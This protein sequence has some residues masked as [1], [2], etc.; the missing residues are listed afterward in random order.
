MYQT[1]STKQY[2]PFMQAS[3]FIIRKTLMN[4]YKTFVRPHL[5]YDDVLYEFL[6]VSSTKNLNLFNITHA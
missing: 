4:I 3:K 1:K 2:R 5:D 6:I